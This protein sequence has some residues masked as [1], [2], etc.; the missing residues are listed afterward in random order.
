MNNGRICIDFDGVLNT[1]TGWQGEDVLFEPATGAKEFMEWLHQSQYTVCIFTTRDI[2]KVKEWCTYFNVYFDEITNTKV[3][4]LAYIDDR[5]IHFDGDF[6]RIKKELSEG[7][8]THWE[9]HSTEW[10]SHYDGESDIYR[11]SKWETPDVLWSFKIPHCARNGDS[12]IH[13]ND[14]Q[15]QTLVDKLNDGSIAPIREDI[16]EYSV[17]IERE[18]CNMRF[19]IRTKNKRW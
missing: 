11:I 10:R 8:F 18:L 19:D 2:D 17:V 4:A 16:C 15:I 14:E 12:I 9:Q 5:G 1:Y 7:F 6:D 3:G 13:W